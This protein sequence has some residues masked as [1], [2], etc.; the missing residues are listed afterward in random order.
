M[1]F[2]V[3]RPPRRLRATFRTRICQ[4]LPIIT[5]DVFLNALVRHIDKAVDE[6]KNKNVTTFFGYKR[7]STQFSACHCLWLDAP[8]NI[9]QSPLFSEPR[10]THALWTNNVILFSA[11]A[12]R[13]AET[14]RRRRATNGG[15]SILHHERSCGYY[16]FA[17]SELVDMWRCQPDLRKMTQRGKKLKNRSLSP[18]WA[19]MAL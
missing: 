19:S 2:V 16:P 3:G 9:P 12:V 14:T 1:T 7:P 17:S 18:Q 5:T 6:E 8:G 10:S 11:S 4:Y 13:S 15:P